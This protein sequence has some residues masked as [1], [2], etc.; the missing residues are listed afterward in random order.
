MHGYIY[1]YLDMIY[2]VITLPKA[3]Y[4]NLEQHMS[5]I[6]QSVADAAAAASSPQNSASEHD[7]NSMSVDNSGIQ[8][9][10]RNLNPTDLLDG[11]EQMV[12]SKH[13][14]SHF[15]Q[16]N[17]NHTILSAN[18]NVFENKSKGSDFSRSWYKVPTPLP[19]P[20]NPLYPIMMKLE[21]Q[22][23][24]RT[25]RMSMLAIIESMKGG[26]LRITSL[27]RTKWVSGCAYAT[28][29]LY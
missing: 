12:L 29:M 5:S 24:R 22:S 21:K 27:K 28:L 4:D 1:I 14:L 26:I 20:R 25:S 11:E 3:G 23:T 7:S 18:N 13:L 10:Y 2:I 8:D 15:V 6:P 19:S 16:V 17:F 9:T